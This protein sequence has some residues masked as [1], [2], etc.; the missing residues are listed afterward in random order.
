[1]RRHVRVV[2]PF[3]AGEE[4]HELFAEGAICVRGHEGLMGI[5]AVPVDEEAE[6]AGFFFRGAAWV[7]YGHFERRG[8]LGGRKESELT[9]S[10]RVERLVGPGWF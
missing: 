4:G 8:V 10:M 5:N 6:H 3:D 1:M 9:P 7:R 2:D